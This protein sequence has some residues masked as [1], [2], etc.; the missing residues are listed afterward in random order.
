MF[1]FIPIPH[2]NA[3]YHIVKVF[4][5]FSNLNLYL[6]STQFKRTAENKKKS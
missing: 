1:K 3:H 2:H 4:V 6:D 5:R